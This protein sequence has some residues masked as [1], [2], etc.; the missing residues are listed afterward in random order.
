M[1]VFK[2]NLFGSIAK[3]KP[4]LVLEDPSSKLKKNKK[5][6]TNKQTQVPSLLNLLYKFL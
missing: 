6:K 4:T 1:G 2:D 5:Q 3:L